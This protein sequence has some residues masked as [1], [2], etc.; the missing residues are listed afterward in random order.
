ML[1]SRDFWASRDFGIRFATDGDGAGGGNGTQ[2]G[3]QKGSDSSKDGDQKGGDSKGDDLD[4]VE[5]LGDKGKNAIRAARAE[6]D[7]AKKDLADLTATVK[8]L[9]KFKEDTEKAARDAS[10]E[11]AKNKGKFE[12]LANQ[13]KG[14]A[15]KAQGDLKTANARIKDLE[16]AMAEGQEDQLKELPEEVRALW[17]GDDKGYDVLELYK[18]LN[19]DA[20]KK[21]V[22]KLS[23]SSS[24]DRGNG[25]NPPLGDK[26]VSSEDATKSQAPIYNAF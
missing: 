11:D 18:F 4:G 24:E 5:G 10:E 19:D 1:I 17:K 21:L 7:Q 14:D 20:T 25:K 2:D 15:E 9:Q 26:K 22:A 13:Y 16:A 3:D 23:G 8:D 12:E 6:R